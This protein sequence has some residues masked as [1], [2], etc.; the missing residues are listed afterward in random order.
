MLFMLET[1]RVLFPTAFWSLEVVAEV[2]VV[3]EGFAGWKVLKVPEIFLEPV[4]DTA[5]LLGIPCEH[6]FA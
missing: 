4:L 5:W 2:R 6:F 3:E 1:H